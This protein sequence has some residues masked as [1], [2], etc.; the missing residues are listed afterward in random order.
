MTAS[1]PFMPASFSPPASG[2]C[3]VSLRWPLHTKRACAVLVKQLRDCRQT[4]AAI[5]AG[6]THCRHVELIP[7]TAVDCRAYGGVVDGAAMTDDRA[8]LLGLYL[9]PAQSEEEGAS[10]GEPVHTSRLPDSTA[11]PTSGARR[12]G[13]VSAGRRRRAPT[14]C[15][16]VQRGLVLVRRLRRRPRLPWCVVLPRVGTPGLRLWSKRWRA[17][18]GADSRVRPGSR[19]D[20]CPAFAPRD[21]PSDAPR[22]AA[23]P[24]ERYE[25]SHNVLCTQAPTV[26]SVPSQEAWL[27]PVWAIVACR[28]W[29]GGSVQRSGGYERSRGRLSPDEVV[30]VR[31]RDK[32]HWSGAAACVCE[33]VRGFPQ[34]SP[35]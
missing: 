13:G 10:S 34:P 32:S 25:R 1:L 15:G 24:P 5:G 11:V 18:F 3:C 17:R 22:A 26:R 27:H 14:S 31:G 16:C 21:R 2:Y 7:R 30:D 20:G 33:R 35:V 29:L 4:A 9:T 28:H 6:A 12:A 19:G 8:S 23:W